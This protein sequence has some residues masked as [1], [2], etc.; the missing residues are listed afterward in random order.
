MCGALISRPAGG[1]MDF[2][3][4]IDN[5]R[6]HTLAYENHVRGEKLY[7]AVVDAGFGCP[8]IDGHCGSGGCIYCDGGSG[9]FTADS[10]LSIT[11]QLDFELGRIRKK[12]PDANAIAY[13][14]AHTNTYASAETLR[15]LYLEALSH[16]GIR[17]LSVATRADCL[18]NSV[19][20]LLSELNE[21][22]FLT[23]ELGLQTVH[24]K[25][26]ALINRGHDFECFLQGFSALRRHG[27]RVTVHIINGLPDE[28]GPMMLE[29]ARVLGQLRPDGVKIHLLHVISGTR[30]WEMYMAGQYVPMD[31]DNYTKTVVRQLELLPPET[32]IERLTGDGDKKKLCAP[33]WSTDKIRVLGTIDKLMAQHDTWQGKYYMNEETL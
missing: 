4:S 16:E 26:A 10:R 31:F 6:Y 25:T 33:L 21:K 28:D 2:P 1:F 24:D 30:L 29:T 3:F 7:K 11:A 20:E 8:N 9:Y 22:T 17:G 5:K 19:L 13:F 12:V 14:Q 27:I 18:D 23:V 32:V 15:R